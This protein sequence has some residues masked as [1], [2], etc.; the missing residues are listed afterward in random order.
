MTV[1]LS[2]W[3]APGGFHFGGRA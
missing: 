2:Y 3:A 1:V